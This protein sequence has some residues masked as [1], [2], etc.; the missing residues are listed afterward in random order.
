MTKKMRKVKKTISLIEVIFLLLSLSVP[1]FKVQ[2]ATPIP[3]VAISTWIKPTGSS[4]VS[5]AIITKNNEFR[6]VTDGSGNLLCQEHDGAGWNY[7]VASSEVLQIGKWQHVGCSIY[8]TVGTISVYVNGVQKGIGSGYSSSP[9]NTTNHLFIGK[10]ASG[11]YGDFQGYIDEPKIRN[12]FSGTGVNM[13]IEFK[14][15]YNAGLAGNGS[16][17]GANVTVGESPKWMT[18]GLVGHWKMDESSGTSVAD[19][20]GNANT[21][22]LT[23]AQETG[24]SDDSGNTVTTLVD[25]SNA[26][27]STTNDAYNGM[28]LRFTSACRSI[29]SGTERTITDY[30]YSGSTSTFTV[31]TLAEAPYSCAFEIRHQTGGKFGNGMAFDGTNDTVAIPDSN[32]WTFVEADDVTIS[33]WINL[34][35]ATPDSYANIWGD[36]A[37]PCL[38]LQKVSANVYQLL[39]SSNGLSPGA[40]IRSPNITINFN[41]WYHVSVVRRSDREV[42]LYLNGNVVKVVPKSSESTTNPDNVQIGNDTAGEK[43]PGMIDDVRVYK[44]NALQPDQVKQ[45]SEWGPGP[46]GWW[47]MDEGSGGTAHDISGN[48]YNLSL[49]STTWKN[50]KYGDA[51]N[52][53]GSTSGAEF[54][55]SDQTGLDMKRMT[56]S[57]WI[58]TNSCDNGRYYV[59]GGK[60]LTYRLWLYGVGGGQCSLNFETTIDGG[61]WGTQGLTYNYINIGQWYYVTAEFDGTNKKLYVNGSQASASSVSGNI[62]PGNEHF[63]IGLGYNNTM[64]VDGLID[65]VR[66]YNYARTPKQITEDLNAGHPIGGSPVGSPVGYWK[67]DEGYGTS[68]TQDSSQNNQDM[69]LVNTPTW[70]NSGKF[71]RALDFEKDSSEY[72]WTADSSALSI[73]SD[74]T[75]SAWIK[76]ESNSAITEYVIAGKWTTINQSYLLAQWGSEL[77]M[78]IDSGSNYKTT[79]GLGLQVGQWYYVSG[80]YSASAQTVTLY[81]NG[82][83]KGGSVTGTIP[84]S[85]GDD[86]EN[87]FIGSYTG[88]GVA[89]AFDGLIDE[90]KVY[91]SALTPDQIALDMNHGTEMQLGGQTSATGAT[92]QAA[93]YCVPGSSDSCAGPVG[94]WKFDEGSGG[95]VNDTSGNGA[96]GSWNG[97]GTRWTVDGK[98]NNAG[99]FNGS[100]DYVNFTG[101]SLSVKT[102]S[103]W[104]KPA[105]ISPSNQYF[106]VYEGGSQWVRLDNGTIVVG[107]PSSNVIYVDGKQST[108]FPNANWHYVTVTSDSGFSTTNMIFGKFSTFYFSGSI[109]DVRMYN[110]V[111][112]PAQIAWDYNRGKPVGW[113]KMDEGEGDKAYDSSGNGNVGTLTTMDPPTDWVDGKFG[114]ALDFDGTSDYV[115]TTNSMS[116]DKASFS[117]SAWFKTTTSS[118]LK[119]L[120]NNT[121]H[122]LQ[123]YNGHLR[124]CVTTCDEGTT[125]VNDGNWHFALVEGDGS[126]V[127]AYLDGK[128]APE[129][130]QSATSGNMTG[131]FNI[132][133]TGTSHYFLGRIDDVRIY[134]YALT[135]TQIQQIRNEG[136]AV[137][138][139]E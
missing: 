96:V 84:S 91:N 8:K 82:V 137:R 108:S 21:G 72:A 71:G 45:L 55:N 27:L 3:S 10:D 70:T 83:D 24:T 46:V 138:F 90:V 76:P 59:I 58:K 56:I 51:L 67:M 106:I 68:T 110:Y 50:G 107:F 6:L 124:I 66:V 86:T 109:D 85:I 128:T 65:D 119:I 15:D 127:R 133:S 130:T 5:K 11:T 81:V 79:S 74:L 136:S 42:K 23:N 39:W 49:T 125:A 114:K 117:A 48:G 62:S 16:T 13:G 36:E 98:Y 43:F 101:L 126:S 89:R 73:T 61:G 25:T 47:K 95:S 9:N 100:D 88:T 116:V 92:G 113:W 97:T 129:I 26:S 2:A 30:A 123:V 63:K 75:V 57:A 40:T 4:L 18:D 111:R 1:L 54:T 120:S 139:G 64:N 60:D 121:S 20:S 105:S 33:A 78:S 131:I 104:A 132:G 69:T 41:S 35:W 28:I 77:R 94:E 122:P 115:A 7:S 32:L 80:V 102:L 99:K 118:D 12:Q 34:A 38:Q 19:A 44:G 52:F 29:T 134:N 93:E 103:F 135:Q 87:F 31:A 17:E 14:K 53:D 112:T 37:G 22:T